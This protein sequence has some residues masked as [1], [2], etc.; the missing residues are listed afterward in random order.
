MN[1]PAISYDPFDYALQENPY[2]TY[3]RLRA[4]APVF[5]NAERGFY[6][7]SRFEDCNDAVRDYKRFSNEGGSALEEL[8]AQTSYLNNSDPPD[9]TRLRRLTVALFTPAQL[10]P[11]ESRIRELSR[12]LL[13]PFKGT[14]RIEIIEDFA[15]KLPIAIICRLLGVPPEDEQRL[16]HLTDTIMHREDGNFSM[17]QSAIDATVGLYEYFGGLLAKRAQEP[18]RDDMIGHL[19]SEQA[20][21]NLSQDELIGYLHLLSIAGNETT[22]KMIGTMCVLLDRHPDQA[23]AI[24]K[25]PSLLANAIE[26]GLRYDGPAQM[27]ARKTTQ[28]I[29]LHGT[30]IPAGARVALV[31]GAANRDER[32]FDDAESFD[33]TRNTRGHLGLGGGIHVCLGGALARME[34]RVAM[35]EILVA[36]GDFAVERET[37]ERV[38]SPNVHGYSKVVLKF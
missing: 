19:L 34:T 12:E 3:R 26:E 20:A 38:H 22:T 2:P 5:H 33:V 28:D 24:R 29:T 36:F 17:P 30:T 32:K 25:D 31:F 11:I 9:H 4:E 14:G 37:L 35:E 23:A 27:M 7:L 15:A 13:A 6:A 21:G 1:E 16:R 8:E 18:P 10:A